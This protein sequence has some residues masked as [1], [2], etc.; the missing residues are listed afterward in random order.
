MYDPPSDWCRRS[1]SDLQALPLSRGRSWEI[2]RHTGHRIVRMEEVPGN[3]PHAPS[4]RVAEWKATQSAPRAKLI[5][6][7]L[8]P[9]PR[10]VAG[11]DMA[12]SSD[13]ATAYAV[14]VV[15]DRQE[16]R[17]VETATAVRPVDAPYIP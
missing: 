10:F 3:A 6:S 15:Y 5:V 13:K 8:R 2:I 16:K 14:A 4:N 17:V 12:Y 9:L 11:A 7:P 1:R